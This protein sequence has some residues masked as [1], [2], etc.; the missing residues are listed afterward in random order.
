MLDPMAA[1]SG[2]TLPAHGLSRATLPGQQGLAG[3]SGEKEPTH[4]VFQVP[5]EKTK[6]PTSRSCINTS[7]KT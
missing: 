7:S 5:R 3:L 2:T 6:C 1:K 4:Q